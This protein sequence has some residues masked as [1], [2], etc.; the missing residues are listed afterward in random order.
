MGPERKTRLIMILQVFA[1]AGQ[2][3]LHL[4]AVLRQLAGGADAGGQQQHR[5]VDGAAGQDQLAPRADALDFSVALDLDANRAA[6]LEQD[7][8]DMG[9]RSSI[10]VFPVEGSAGDSRPRSSGASHC[11]R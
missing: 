5:R 8:S 1:D 6:A 3:Q 7:F 2:I 9:F 11:G 10:P 4:D